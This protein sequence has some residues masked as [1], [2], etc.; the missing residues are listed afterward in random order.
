MDNS[1]KNRIMQ[2]AFFTAVATTVYFLESIAVRLLPF[3]FLRIGLANVIILYLLL[4]KEF[5]F[6]FTVNIMKTLIGGLISL[7]L[8]SPA[9]LISICG[10]IGSMLVMWL[11]LVSHIRFSAIGISIAGAVVHNIIQVFVVRW[12]ILQRDSIFY[13][14]PVLMLIGIVTGFVTGIIAQ[15]LYQKLEGSKEC[16]DKPV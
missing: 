4:K 11:L 15:E 13:L 10:G 9:T 8:L 5:V 6:A 1:I 7:T 14:L 2:Y 12:V 3:P 16:E